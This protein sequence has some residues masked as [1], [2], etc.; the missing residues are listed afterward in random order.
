MTDTILIPKGADRAVGPLTKVTSAPAACAARAKAY[1]IFPD[2][3]L[4]MPR[5]GSIG[6]KV[7][8]AV[9]NTFL[10]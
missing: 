2:E 6:S 4:V 7:G 1:P 10:A 9:I 3:R 5:T 8:P